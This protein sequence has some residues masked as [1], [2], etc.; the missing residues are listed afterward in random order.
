MAI[1]RAIVG[2]ALIA[3]APAAGAPRTELS[4]GGAD[5]AVEVRPGS[6]DLP[7]AE[8]VAWIAAGAN[9]VTGYY[10]RFPVARYRI[11]IAPVAG[12]AGVLGGTTWAHG[13]AHSRILVG[14]HTTRAHL[15]R[16]W[17][18]T[19]EMIHTAFPDQ[20]PSHRWIEEGTATYVEPLARSWA[21]RYPATRVWADLVDGLPKGLPAAGDRGLDHTHTWGRTYWGGALFCLLAD[22]AIRERTGGRR[23]LVD[24]L[25]A[26]VAAGG[27]NQADWTIERAFREGDKAIGAPVLSELYERMKDAPVATDLGAI[28]RDLGVE[29]RRGTVELDDG[30]PKAAIRRAITARPP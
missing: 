3:C 4:I 7:R 2:L 18:M 12:K 14:E 13:G 25:R 28:W 20:S 8:L 22:I 11:A 1:V 21:G 10:G 30:A 15:A 23:G 6:L 24:A 17:I 9:A 16:D 19:H 26:I 29:P 5:I 27:N